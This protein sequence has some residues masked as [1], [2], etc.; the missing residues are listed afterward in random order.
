M[1]PYHGISFVDKRPGMD[2]VFYHGR[3]YRV[4]LS[5]SRPRDIPP[6]HPVFV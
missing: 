2:T 5:H 3:F 1:R 4:P 6:A